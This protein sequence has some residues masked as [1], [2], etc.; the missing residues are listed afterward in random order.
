MWLIGDFAARDIGERACRGVAVFG[1][2]DSQFQERR[3][4]VGI[5]SGLGELSPCQGLRVG[6][7]DAGFCE[8][9]GLL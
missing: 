7:T 5:T 9:L 2:D 1:G 8:I 6:D 3:G 4:V